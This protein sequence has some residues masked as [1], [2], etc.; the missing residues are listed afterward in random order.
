MILDQVL[1]IKLISTC[2][3]VYF[4]PAFSWN[5]GLNIAWYV[6]LNFN[7]NIYKY[8]FIFAISHWWNE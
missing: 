5:Y 1:Q 2:L 4:P 7:T 8:I 6:T 3:L